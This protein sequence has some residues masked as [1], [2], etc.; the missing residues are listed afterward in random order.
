MRK[1]RLKHTTITVT[2][3]LVCVATLLALLRAVILHPTGSL[4]E[5]G[6]ELFVS[7]GC[8]HC[9]FSDSG[10]T[11]IGPGLKGLFEHEKLPVSGRKATEENVRKQLRTP[12]ENM[13]SFAD[14]LTME[15]R[16]QLI[17]Y[18]KTL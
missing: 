6:P 7:Q 17:F 2:I 13:P 18:L 4:S 15:Q 1:T 9:H 12:Y 14:K 11:K 8:A 5:K 16:D 10:K 3:T